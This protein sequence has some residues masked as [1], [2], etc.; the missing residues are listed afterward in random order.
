MEFIDLH[1]GNI[2]FN[3]RVKDWM[4]DNGVTITALAKH[5]GMSRASLSRRLNYHVSWRD[6]DKKVMAVVLCEDWRDDYV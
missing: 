4:L 6:T 5:L 3:Q 2:E 1:K